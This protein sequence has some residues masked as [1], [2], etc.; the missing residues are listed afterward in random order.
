MDIELL[1]PPAKISSATRFTWHHH[2]ECPACSEHSIEFAYQFIWIG[3]MFECVMRDND[4]NGAICDLCQVRVYFYSSVMRKAD[5]VLINL[6][7]DPPT[8][9]D[10]AEN[11]SSAASKIQDR[12]IGIDSRSKKS[13]RVTLGIR[14]ASA[15]PVS[16]IKPSTIARVLLNGHWQRGGTAP[17]RAIM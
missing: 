14:R 1:S 15:L 8:A 17:M 7:S 11:P 9:F 12:R 5:R 16:E 6:D 13:R 3:S 2:D 10:F 4:I